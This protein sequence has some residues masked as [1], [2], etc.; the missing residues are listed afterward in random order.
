M[1]RKSKLPKLSTIYNKL[2]KLAS[3]KCRTKAKFRC[4]CCGRSTK[5]VSSNGKPLILN[6]HHIISR[7]CSDFLRFNPRN[8][9][10]LCS[11]CHTFGNEISA[12]KMSMVFAKWYMDKYP[13]NFEWLLKNIK[14]PLNLKDRN[15]LAQIEEELKK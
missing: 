8:L 12:H 10:S 4:E 6:A 1:K 5:D 14:T 15:V 7:H 11:R 13:E 9:I 2:Y 3:L